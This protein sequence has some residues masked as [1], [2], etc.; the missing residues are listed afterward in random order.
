M[1]KDFSRW[2]FTKSRFLERG[3]L[4]II[5]PEQ[6]FYGQNILGYISDPHLQHLYTLF[7]LRM[8]ECNML[9]SFVSCADGEEPPLG[10]NMR[11]KYRDQGMASLH[12]SSGAQD[13]L[14][15]RGSFSSLACKKCRSRPSFTFT[16][17]GLC[18]SMNPGILQSGLPKKRCCPAFTLIEERES[19][20]HKDRGFF[21]RCPWQES[22][23]RPLGPQPNALS[24]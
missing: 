1:S 11:R 7:R 9:T 15:H 22:N 18:L 16:A 3:G 5:E 23:L 20:C 19:P 21:H 8:E 24:T 2:L 4:A 6:E 17:A 13:S 12:A 10:D 14:G